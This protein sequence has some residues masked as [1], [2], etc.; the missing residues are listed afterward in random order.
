M[1]ST[2]IFLFRFGGNE[3]NVA[4][5]LFVFPQ[6]CKLIAGAYCRGPL[7]LFAGNCIKYNGMRSM[8]KKSVRGMPRAGKPFLN[9]QP[10]IDQPASPAPVP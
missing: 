4:D 8:E 6:S 5:S 10:F 9:S 1:K 2:M 7:Y 3:K